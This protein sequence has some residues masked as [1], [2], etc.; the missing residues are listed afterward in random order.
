MPLSL[1]Q[2]LKLMTPGLK[3]SWKHN[4]SQPETPMS[5]GIEV[6]KNYCSSINKN[7]AISFQNDKSERN[8]NLLWRPAF[9]LSKKS[10]IWTY[11]RL[12]FNSR[13]LNLDLT[14][15]TNPHF[16]GAINLHGQWLNRNCWWLL[17][18]QTRGKWYGIPAG[19]PRILL[20]RPRPFN[21]INMP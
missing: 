14:A 9:G 8:W 13:D 15:T 7:E 3:T 1:L 6:R 21:G 18:V 12:T 20:I 2:T 16:G 4:A 17:S 5:E 19:V 10:W 11:S